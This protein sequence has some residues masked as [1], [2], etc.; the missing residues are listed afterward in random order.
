MLTFAAPIL[1]FG[2]VIF[3]HEFGHFVAAKL[4]GVYA[5][6]FS[7]GFGPALFR[8]RHGETEYVLAALPLGGYVRMASK[9]D[10]DQALLEGGTEEGSAL[11]PGDPGYDPEAMIPFGPKPIPESRKFESKGL[12]ARLFIMVAGVVMNVVLAWAVFVLINVR[13]GEP[14]V[15]SR[16]I[17]GV[18]AAPNAPTLSQLQKGDTI[19]QVNGAPVRNWNQI[20]EAFAASESGTVSIATNRATV[21]V[22]VGGAGQLTGND[23]IAAIDVKLPPVIGDVLPETPAAKAGLQAG[24]SIVTIGGAP[25][26][27]WSD[28]LE[29]VSASAGAEL[30]FEVVRAGKRLPFTLR[31]ESTSVK[32]PVTKQPRVVGRI[33]AV[34][35]SVTAREPMPFGRSLTVAVEQTWGV[36][37]RIVDVVHRLITREVPLNQLGGPIA[38]SRASVAAARNGFE[39]LLGLIAML[40]VNVAVLNLLPIPILDGGQIL[41]NIAEAAKGTPFSVRTREYILRV[42]L[43][44][45]LMIFVLST[46]NDLKALLSRV[47]AHA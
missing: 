22:P 44:L 18:H 37:G 11:K 8:K 30:Q 12:P 40:S 34:N 27:D 15:P 39:D 47:F 7:I 42:G 38:I 28:L 24:D 45:I 35:A 19:L 21:Q 26:G 33:G 9:L 20:A 31:P 17:G 16:V 46:F 10:A 29:H 25:I 41:L 2:L 23:L 1:V 14:V 13:Y 4:T 43:V 32:D 36:G 5:P 3:V 6:R